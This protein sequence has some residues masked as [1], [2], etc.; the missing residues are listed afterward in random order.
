MKDMTI[1]SFDERDKA[2]HL[3]ERLE[4]AGIPCEVFDESRLQKYSFLSKPHAAVKLRVD[5]DDFDEA[6][7]LL[8]GLD[9]VEDALHDAVR[10]PQCGSSRVEYPQFTR[11]FVTPTFVEIFCFLHLMERE[12]YCED[13]QFTWPDHPVK[14]PPP[15]DGS[16]ELDILGF[17]K[18]EGP[19]EDQPS[20]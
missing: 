7:R 5:A 12:F 9:A 2:D 13:C 15:W 3:R 6:R 16:G 11:K 8:A 17:R 14:M 4:K 18:K 1:A 10:C 19:E 20:K